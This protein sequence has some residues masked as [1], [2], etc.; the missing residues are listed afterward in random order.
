MVLDSL[1]AVNGSPIDPVLLAPVVA[2]LGQSRTLPRE[3][4]ISRDV[5][6]WES[7]HFFE[8]SWVCAGRSDALRDAG[9]QAAVRVGSEGVLLVRDESGILRGFYNTCRHRGHEL[10]PCGVEPINRRA[11]K[12]PYHA[13][14]YGLDG[15]L[16]G[17]PR[18]GHLP[19]DDPVHEGLTPARIEEWN[20]WIFV[21]A[22]GNAPSFADH[23]GN[24]DSAVDP[25]DPARLVVAASHEY[26]IEANWKIV[27]ENY[28]EC[29]HCPQIHPEL[30]RVSPPDSGENFL[31][32][33]AWAGGSMDLIEHAE[34]MSISG[35]SESRPLPGVP[36]SL[37]RNVFYVGLFPNLLIS[38][39]PD[40]VMTHRIEPLG[41]GQSRIE[42]QWLFDPDEVARPGFDPAYA[43]EFWDVTNR[44]DWA[45]CASVQR[46]VSSRGY[47]QGPLA[48]QE[49]AVHQFLCIVA[50]GYLD[51]VPSRPRTRASL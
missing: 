30:C 12:C 4:Y 33:G 50:N 26:V 43:V 5:F 46:G 21:N 37:R 3:A 16:R 10:L 9:A 40:Y 39:H 1:D 23:V 8:G 41:P 32:D 31:P 24:L 27:V 19:E 48:P 42:C 11:I 2:P 28:H 35:K 18:F 15:R 34:T 13:W 25:Y 36:E 51:G 6:D 14:V 38:P 7:R 29:Y 20:G 17:A 22:S 45:A 44:Q 49:D 47:R